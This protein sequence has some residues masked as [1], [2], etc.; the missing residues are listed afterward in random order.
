M[1]DRVKIF[2]ER[3]SGT[4]AL[5]TIVRSN[6]QSLYLPSVER[7]F[8]PLLARIVNDRRSPIPAALRERLNDWMF[9]DPSPLNAWKHCATNFPNASAFEGVLVLFTVRHPASWLLSLFKHPYHQLTPKAPD[10]RSFAAAPWK[11]V[12]R[13]RL[14]R[15]S[16]LPLELYRLKLR[17]QLELA[18]RLSVR[19]IAYRFVRHED[20]VLRQAGVF[21]S[22]REEL[23][24]P[25]ADF[26]ESGPQAKPGARPLEHYRTYYGGE[27]WRQELTGLERMINDQVDWDSLR[28]FDYLPL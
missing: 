22:I 18:D 12:G 3:N 15:G 4:H 11:T 6:S 7:E 28:R 5:A 9:R 8:H 25:A 1:N 24:N 27:L 23:L 16:F 2:G 26:V 17:A 21:S 10:L 13:E 20:L 19:A 14:D